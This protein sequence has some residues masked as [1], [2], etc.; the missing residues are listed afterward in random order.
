MIQYNYDTTDIPGLNIHL[1][2]A[3]RDTN[4]QEEWQCLNGK[5][6]KMNII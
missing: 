4:F 5:V 2:V 6:K 3:Y 1:R